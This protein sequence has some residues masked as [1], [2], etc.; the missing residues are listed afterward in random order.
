MTFRVLSSCAKGLGLYTP[1]QSVITCGPPQEGVRQLFIAKAISKAGSRGLSANSTPSSW[2]NK[3]FV[4]EVNLDGTPQ[5][6]PHHCTCLQKGLAAQQQGWVHLVRN[7][8]GS[9]IYLTCKLTGEPASFVAAGRRHR[10]PGSETKGF[11][12]MNRDKLMVHQE[13]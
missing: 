10:T 7:C 9:D 2:E 1:C 8:E 13:A 6:P 3:F 5:H 12:M 4:P 11:I